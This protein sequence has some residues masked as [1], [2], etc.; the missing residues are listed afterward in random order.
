MNP[1]GRWWTRALWPAPVEP[2]PVPPADLPAGLRGDELV[3]ALVPTATRMVAA[4]HDINGDQVQDVLAEATRLAG[5]ELAGLRH[6]VLVLAA[7]CPDDV[8]AAEALAW[9]AHPDE[10]AR[11]RD[12]GVDSLTASLRAS[13]AAHHQQGA[14]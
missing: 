11:L 8:P 7:I 14:A 12:E 13:R 10:Y 5:G 3:D 1:V 9:T 4:V 2:A 6:L